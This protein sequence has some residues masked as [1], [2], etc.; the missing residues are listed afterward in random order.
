MVIK[1]MIN[2]GEIFTANKIQRQD[3]HVLGTPFQV[4]LFASERKNSFTPMRFC[5]DLDNTLVSYPRINGDYNTCEPLHNN[6]NYLRHLKSQGH[7]IIIYTARRMKTWRG[8]I[9][10]VIA[11]IGEITLNSLNKFN[12]PYDEI[13]FGKPYADF[14]I[15]DLAINTQ[16]NLERETGFHVTSISELSLIHI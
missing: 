11:D 12:I 3:F 15:D 14:Y 7:T 16:S 2:N 4:K 9:G 1:R 8:N 5:F 6:I 10:S 13:Y